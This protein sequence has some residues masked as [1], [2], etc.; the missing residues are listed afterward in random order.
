[1]TRRI[2]IVG[3]LQVAMD[4]IMARKA[5]YRLVIMENGQPMTTSMLKKRFDDV[6]G[7]PTP[8]KLTSRCAIYWRSRMKV[9]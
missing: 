6:R 7:P 4:R 8:R 2:E 5:F 9:N 1:V 3:E